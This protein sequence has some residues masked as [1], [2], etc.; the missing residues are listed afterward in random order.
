M[1]LLSTN[2]LFNTNVPL[3]KINQKNFAINGRCYNVK[4]T[5]TY[6]DPNSYNNVNYL[7]TSNSVNADTALGM[8]NF[9]ENRYIGKAAYVYSW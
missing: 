5:N 7:W 9:H 8:A 6:L 2:Y 1:L 3:P 4:N